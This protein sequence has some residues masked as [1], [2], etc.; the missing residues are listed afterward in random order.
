MR[1]NTFSTFLVK[2]WN[3]RVLNF[4]AEVM[5]DYRNITGYIW[6]YFDYILPYFSPFFT[7]KTLISQKLLI[8][9]TWNHSHWIWHTPKPECRTFKQF[10]CI[11]PTQNQENVNRAKLW[12]VQK[13][14]FCFNWTIMIWKAWNWEHLGFGAC[15]I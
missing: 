7:P 4:G 8:V 5:Q 6:F 3:C 1:Y 14:N 10:Q 2:K 13:E 15:R 11:F 9:D 12:L